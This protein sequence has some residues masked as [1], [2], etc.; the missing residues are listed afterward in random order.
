VELRQMEVQRR[1]GD[2]R[3]PQ[4]YFEEDFPQLK[5]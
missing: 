2:A 1:Q 5:G 3:G 4:E